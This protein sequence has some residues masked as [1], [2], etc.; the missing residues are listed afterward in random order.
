M[1]DSN[2]KGKEGRVRH[3]ALPDHLCAR[4]RMTKSE[5]SETTS[6]PHMGLEAGSTSVRQ[7]WD[8]AVS[9]VFFESPIVRLL[10]L[11]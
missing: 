2:R 7:A 11:G 10:G 9:K 5:I 3:A 1:A 8:G 6:M 4:L